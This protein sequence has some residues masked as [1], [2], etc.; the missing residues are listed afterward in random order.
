V[1]RL[2]RRRRDGGRD[3]RRRRGGREGSVGLLL[4]VWREGGRE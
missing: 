4:T 1:Q 2:R 3:G